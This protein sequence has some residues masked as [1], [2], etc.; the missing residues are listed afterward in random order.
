VLLPLQALLYLGLCYLTG[1]K[2]QALKMSTNPV[3]YTSVTVRESERS[4]DRRESKQ[5]YEEVT[6]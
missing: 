4:N 3:Y 2:F 1:L 6:S 5:L